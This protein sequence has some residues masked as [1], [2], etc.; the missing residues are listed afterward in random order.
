MKRNRYFLLALILATGVF[1]SFFGGNIPHALF[2]SSLVIPV[3]SFLYTVYVFLRFRLYQKIES[4]KV[5]KGELVP[6][7]F[8]LANEDFISYT[9]IRVNF[10]SESSYVSDAGEK[11]DYLLL[12]GDSSTMKTTLCCRYRGEYD[13]GVKSVVITDFLC[14]FSVTY[15]ITTRLNLTVLPRV[16]KLSNTLKSELDNKATSFCFNPNSDRPDT[17]VRKYSSGD[18]MKLIHWKATARKQ[19][20]LT[21]KLTE[22]KK[23]DISIILDLSPVRENP[24]EKIIIE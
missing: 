1:A 11:T 18:S 10:F 23:S 20:L 22:I 5:M 12:P 6:Y 14:L 2:Y 15:P 13:V 17:D 9:G 3:V 21:R 19:S 24:F 4:R 16:H 8:T 7:E